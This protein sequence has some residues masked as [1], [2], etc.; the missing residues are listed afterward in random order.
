MEDKRNRGERK[1][2]II[3][4]LMPSKEISHMILKRRRRGMRTR[5]RERSAWGSFP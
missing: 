1:E 5:R 4:H 3:E 2:V